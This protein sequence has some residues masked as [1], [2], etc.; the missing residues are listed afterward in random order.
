ML[1]NRPRAEAFMAKRGVDALVAT[2]PENVL[3]A[4]DHQCSTHWINKGAQV[5][6]ALLPGRAPEA[7]LIV[8]ML[9]ADT[10]TESRSWIRDITFVGLFSRAP[11]PEAEMDATGR[12]TAATL[13]AARTAPSAMAGL[14]EVI[15][16]AGLEK[17][18]IGIDEGGIP[19]SIWRQL[20]QMLPDATL[21]PATNLWWEIRMVKTPE[22]IRRLR[23]AS[24]VTELAMV[25]ALRLARPGATERDMILKY[26]EVLAI[27][28]AR[29]T[30]SMIGSGTR[31]AQPHFIEGDRRLEA[32]DLLRWDIGCTFDY[33]HSDTARAVSMGEPTAEQSRIWDLLCRGVEDAIAKVKP[34]AD[35]RE[36]FETAMAPGRA[37]GLPGFERFHCGH[38]I[39]ISVYDPP[40]ITAMD[41]EKS[42]FLMPAAEGGL[43]PGMT[44]NIEVGYYIAGRMGF[45]CEDTLLV[46]ESGNDRL[47]HAP[48]SLRLKDWL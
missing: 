12:A 13:A 23:E 7:A 43:Q 48:K 34:G 9:E 47:T 26:H 30:F 36:V 2:S 25:E 3:Y 40:I 4:S 10:L 42:V 11:T 6:A 28:A 38:G 1:L 33:Y 15:R 22:E 29:P 20:E 14:V 24:R 5:Y 37:A 46:T 8:P 41:P 45:L 21:V 32:G 27:N 16:R 31:T 44:I 17:A 35:P 19:P 18:R 39:G